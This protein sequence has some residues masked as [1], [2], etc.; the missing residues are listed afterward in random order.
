MPKM[1]PA[2]TSITEELVPDI[3]HLVPVTKFVNFRADIHLR[4]KH[5]IVDTHLNCLGVVCLGQ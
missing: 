4:F 1:V 3:L 2:K 5:A